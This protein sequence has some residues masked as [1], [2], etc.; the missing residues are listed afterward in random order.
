[1]HSSGYYL[2]CVELRELRRFG[3]FSGDPAVGS[4]S[5]L[6]LSI[7]MHSSA[8]ELCSFRPTGVAIYNGK[9]EPLDQIPK[10]SICAALLGDRRV[11]D[12]RGEQKRKLEPLDALSRSRQPLAGG[13]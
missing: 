8:P 12:Q 9:R 5:S 3:C 11:D 1:M 6:S 4:G 10:Y 7:D 13:V 2:L